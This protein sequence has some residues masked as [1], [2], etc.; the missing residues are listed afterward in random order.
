[1]TVSVFLMDNKKYNPSKNLNFIFSESDTYHFYTK[2]M[3]FSS[4]KHG[5]LIPVRIITA[6]TESEAS[7]SLSSSELRLSSR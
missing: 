1:M 7:E 6:E 2:Y 4:R 5:Y 3:I